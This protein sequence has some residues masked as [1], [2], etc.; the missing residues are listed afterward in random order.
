MSRRHHSWWEFARRS[1]IVIRILAALLLLCPAALCAQAPDDPIIRG[2]QAYQRGDYPNA[3]QWY[4]K[5]LDDRGRNG[6]PSRRIA[7]AAC[8]LEAMA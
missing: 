1:S 5:G 7:S 3:I 4:R 2:D 6:K 8:S